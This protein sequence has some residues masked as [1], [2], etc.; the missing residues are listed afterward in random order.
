MSV[1]IE[2]V[3]APDAGVEWVPPEQPAV[4]GQTPGPEFSIGALVITGGGGVAF[5]GTRGEILD[6]L[7]RAALAVPLP[8]VDDA[9]KLL[10]AAIR[11]YLRSGGSAGDPDTCEQLDLLLAHLEGGT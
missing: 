4:D 11:I 2:W 8:T 1:R 5:G 3:Y 7:S 9:E 6:L 10:A